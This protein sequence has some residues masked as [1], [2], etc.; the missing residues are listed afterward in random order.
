MLKDFGEVWVVIG[1]KGATHCSTPKF[2]HVRGAS[3]VLNPAL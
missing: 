3:G 1:C 2:M